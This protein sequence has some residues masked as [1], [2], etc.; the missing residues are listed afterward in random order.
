MKQVSKEEL[1]VLARELFAPLVD[2]LKAEVA[3][4]RQQQVQ[5]QKALEGAAAAHRDQ[6]TS[7][8]E[9]ARADLD[10]RGKGL[11][12]LK[13]DLLRGRASV[14]QLL[15]ASMESFA[16]QRAELQAAC[17][18]DIVAAQKQLAA[19]TARMVDMEAKLAAEAKDS[20]ERSI[21]AAREAQ[22]AAQKFG[23]QVTALQHQ[24]DGFSAGV[25]AR[26]NG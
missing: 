9:R 2:E 4:A 11:E 6:I 21:K 7:L 14:Q 10:A 3:A 12:K 22:A 23:D 17:E 8:W 5:S 18:A 13:A 20:T 15:D 16:K 19:T 24:F 1:M 25:K 26:F